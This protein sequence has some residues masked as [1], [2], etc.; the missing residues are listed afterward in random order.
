MRDWHSVR[1][2]KLA[3]I[4]QVQQLSITET[5][6][7][8][9][10]TIDIDGFFITLNKSGYNLLG[11][12]FDK[13]IRQLRLV[14][15]YTKES[16]LQFVNHDTPNA[17][18]FGASHSE[19]DF[20]SVDS[21]LI[22][23]SQVLIAHKDSVGNVEYFSI[24]SR[25]IRSIKEAEKERRE[26]V[27]QLHQAKK[28]ETVG[29]LA[30]GVAHD[31]NNFMS[32]IMGRTERGLQNLSNEVDVENELNIILDSA[33]KAARL[34]HQLLDFSSKQIIERQVLNANDVIQ[35]SQQ[36][37]GSVLGE[38]V[39]INIVTEAL[40]WPIKI[41]RSQLEQVIMNLSVNSSYAMEA[42]GIF[43]IKTENTVVSDRN[44]EALEL[45]CA[46][47][48]VKLTLSDTG[49][50]IEP[51]LLDKIFDPFFTTRD[52][53][54]GTG[55]GL[56]AVFGAV[57]QNDG[58]ISVFSTVDVGTSFEIYFPRELNTNNVIRILQTQDG[59]EEQASH[60]GKVLLVE[61]NA[62]VRE[63]LAS[64]LNDL[65]FEVVEANDGLQALRI[66]QDNDE[67]FDLVVSDITMPNMNGIDLYR[68][69]SGLNSATKV[70]LVSGH[71]DL[72]IPSNVPARHNITLLRKPFPLKN[73]SEIVRK[74][75]AETA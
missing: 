57:K 25:D 44:Y 75:L 14:G 6:T 64:V 30:G 3:G 54:K 71:T 63:L 47:D 74:V 11:L 39:E 60:C 48:Y 58:V 5:T 38:Q 18:K 42:D 13:D 41:D 70:L 24:V 22:P 43:T 51:D 33:Q 27:E 31:F 66:F 19:V 16:I 8:L 55:L 56:S 40:L 61:D 46:G 37:I 73:F 52:V 50:G 68:K 29:R 36:L 28:M 53:D 49:C 62:G 10:A 2:S 72:E 4:Q 1:A 21:S 69:I 9:V 67:T 65:G 15:F 23:S 12:E 17:V 26:L 20:V 35:N 32:I 45:P 34:S 59:I 7:D